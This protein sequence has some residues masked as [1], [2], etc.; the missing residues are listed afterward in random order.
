MNLFQLGNFTLHSGKTSRWK[1]CCEA[2]SPSDWEA[3]AV[4]TV[5][6]LNLPPFMSVEGVPRGGL[7]FAHYLRPFASWQA[8]RPVLLVDDVLTTGASMEVV[9]AGRQAIGV[10]LFARGPLLPW[11]KALFRLP[12]LE[13]KTKVVV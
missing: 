1:I 12:G 3:L 10:V 11:V 8:G 7:D 2:L 4:M 6:E 5:E 9:R 13:C